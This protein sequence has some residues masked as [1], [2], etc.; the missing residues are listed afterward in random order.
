LLLC[1]CRAVYPDRDVGPVVDASQNLAS[2]RYHPVIRPD[3]PFPGERLAF[4]RHFYYATRPTQ[5]A[6][7]ASGE[8]GPSTQFEEMAVYMIR[9]DPDGTPNVLRLVRIPGVRTDGVTSP[10]AHIAIAAPSAVVLDGHPAIRNTSGT[11]VVYLEDGPLYGGF[12]LDVP[13]TLVDVEQT[14]RLLADTRVRVAALSFDGAKVAYV[15]ASGTLRLLDTAIGATPEKALDISALL[16]PVTVTG[17]QW[18][19][20]PSPG[21]LLRIERGC[22]IEVYRV[23]QESGDFGVSTL[24]SG[25]IREPGSELLSA[26]NEIT[27]SISASIWLVPSPTGFDR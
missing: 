14:P 16:G 20:G 3:S 18:E 2:A 22:N 25:L 17:I 11:A 5:W 23:E 6:I 10:R 15:E 27:H 19:P 13:D 24:P 7:L 4:I 26:I 1:G 9:F 12:S 21:L 8:G